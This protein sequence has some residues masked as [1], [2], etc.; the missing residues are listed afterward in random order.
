MLREIEEVK[1]ELGLNTSLQKELSEDQNIQSELKENSVNDIEKSKQEE[2]EKIQTKDQEQI[3]I[4]QL[5]EQAYLEKMNKRPEKKRESM[6]EAA[7]IARYNIKLLE[8][9][10]QAYDPKQAD[11]VVKVFRKG[12]VFSVVPIMEEDFEDSFQSSQN[13]LESQGTQEFAG[14]GL[15]GMASLGSEGKNKNN[16]HQNDDNKCKLGDIKEEN[17]MLF[18]DRDEDDQNTWA[19]KNQS[20]AS[21]NTGYDFENDPN[22]FGTVNDAQGDMNA[23]ALG[24]IGNDPDGKNRNRHGRNQISKE[25][26][27]DY[28]EETVLSPKK[29]KKRRR[30]KAKKMPFND[31]IQ[32]LE[33]IYGP[34]DRPGASV[35]V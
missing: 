3:M 16:K 27:S 32:R 4:Q 29:H 9:I 23:I 35:K 14:I 1:E 15:L 31:K 28:D 18:D 12:G 7:K 13:D 2:E 5:K 20:N 11:N 22:L 25:S 24:M 21:E 26:S 34:S 8:R 33:E 6:G 19:K 17:S 10:Y 30:R